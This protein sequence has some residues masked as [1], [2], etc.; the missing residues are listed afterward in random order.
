MLQRVEGFHRDQA[1]AATEVST[2][3]TLCVGS[4]GVTRATQSAAPCRGK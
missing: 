2:R 1:V 3:S 4:N